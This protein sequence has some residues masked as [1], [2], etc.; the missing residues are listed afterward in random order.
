MITSVEALP[1]RG[2]QLRPGLDVPA[3]AGSRGSPPN[4]LEWHVPPL[5]DVHEWRGARKQEFYR[6]RSQRHVRAH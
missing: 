2:I 4:L 5:T 6:T 3:S 1:R